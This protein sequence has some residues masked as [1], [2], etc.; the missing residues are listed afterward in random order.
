MAAG[1][2]RS[3]TRQGRSW[4]PQDLHGDDG[5]GFPSRVG[6]CYVFRIVRVFLI[7][8]KRERRRM[9]EPGGGK[10]TLL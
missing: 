1:S 9:N 7:P 10:T 2:R 5:V 6:G 4:P 3:L 8:L